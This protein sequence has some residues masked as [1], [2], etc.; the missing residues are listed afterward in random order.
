MAAST[1]ESG[2]STSERPTNKAEAPAT[3]YTLPAWM[4]LPSV[5]TVGEAGAVRPESAD[6]RSAGSNATA[7]PATHAASSEASARAG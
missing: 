2:S 6:G 3:A 4:Q 1:S 5:K 7:G